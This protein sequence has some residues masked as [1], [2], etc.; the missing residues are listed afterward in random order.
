MDRAHSLTFRLEGELPHPWSGSFFGLSLDSALLGCHQQCP[1][2]GIAQ[3]MPPAL[4]LFDASVAAQSAG[5]K[6]KLHDC[7][8]FAG[9]RAPI[10]GQNRPGRVVA[11]TGGVV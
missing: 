3:A 8:F 4:S 7:S 11:G 2:G 9:H 6:K 5:T 10:G 1:F